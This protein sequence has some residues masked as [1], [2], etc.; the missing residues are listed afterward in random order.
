[1]NTRSF[2]TALQIVI[3]AAGAALAVMSENAAAQIFGRVDRI[4]LVDNV[5]GHILTLAPPSPLVADQVVIIPAMKSGGAFVMSNST[6]GQTIANGVTLSGS[7]LEWSNAML[8]VAPAITAA[9]GTYY[10]MISN[11]SASQQSRGVELVAIKA[12]ASGTNELAVGGSFSATGSGNNVAARFA[13]SGGASNTGIEVT[14]GG[15]KIS[16]GIDNNAGGMNEVGSM[17]GVTTLSAESATLQGK[18]SATLRLQP[19]KMASGDFTNI[20]F[21]DGKSREMEIRYTSD[22]TP[23]ISILG[24]GLEVGSGF[25]VSS[26]GDVKAKRLELSEAIPIAKGGTGI[27]ATNVER[28]KIFA[29]PSNA[30]G[31]P[32]FRELDITDLPDLSSLYIESNSSEPQAANLNIDGNA[33]LGGDLVVR[34]AAGIAIPGSSTASV[35]SFGDRQGDRSLQFKDGSGN[36]MALILDRGT[37]GAINASAGFQVAGNASSGSILRGNGSEFVASIAS[38]P[39]V[40]K[41]GELM[42]SSA[43]NKITG[44]ATIDN[45]VL[46]TST[47]G[48]PSI[49]SALPANVQKNITSLGTI[50]SGTWNATPLNDAAVDNKLTI[51]DGT[52]NATPI[53]TA[54]ASTGS[55]TALTAN[56]VVTFSSL[57]A[58]LV[59]S[60]ASGVL[61]ASPISNN[62]IASNAAISGSKI[63]ADFGSQEIRTSGGLNVT[64]GG[65]TLGNANSTVNIPGLL[66]TGTVAPTALVTPNVHG[67]LA[68]G[69]TLNLEGSNNKAPSGDRVTITTD[70]VIRATFDA[71]GAK[72]G[73]DLRFTGGRTIAPV[74]SATGYSLT[75]SGGDATDRNPGARLLLKGGSGSVI[76]TV[77]INTQGGDI[78]LGGRGSQTI[79][80]GSLSVVGGIDN[81]RGGITEAGSITG[82]TSIGASDVTISSFTRPGVVHNDSRG[83][84]ISGPVDLAEDVSGVLDVSS[85]GTGHARVE[86]NL[87]FAGPAAGVVSAAPSFRKLSAGDLPPSSGNYIQNQNTGTQAGAAFNIDGSGFVGGKMVVRGNAILGDSINDNVSLLG[88]VNTS[89][90]FAAGADRS[91]SV[92]TNAPTLAG[93]SLTINAGNAGTGNGGSISINGG[94][95]SGGIAGSVNINGGVSPASTSGSLIVLAG[96]TVTGT[97]GSAVFAGGDASGGGIGGPTIIRGGHTKSGSAGTVS[98]HGG[99]VNGN[100]P[101]AVNIN[102]TGTDGGNV[103]IGN[104]ATMLTL[105]TANLDIS[106]GG[107]ISGATGITSSG[108]ITFSSLESGVVKSKNGSLSASEL[109]I[110]EIPEEVATDLELQ[111]AIANAVNGKRGA[112]AA[113][114]SS[115]SIGEA[116]LSGDVTTKGTSQTTLSATGVTAGSYG[117]GSTVPTI[118]IDAKGRITS[119]ASTSIK[120]AAIELTGNTLAPA[121]T[122]SSLQSVGT[123]TTGAWRGSVIADAYLANDLTITG[124][125]IDATDIGLVTPRNGVFTALSSSGVITGGG[126]ITLGDDGAKAARGSVVLEDATATNGFDATIKSVDQLTDDRTYTLPDLSGT[127]ALIETI[128]KNS[129][130]TPRVSTPLIQSDDRLT[131]KSKGLIVASDIAIDGELKV[132]N[133]STPFAGRAKITAHVDGTQKFTIKNSQSHPTS[134]IIVTPV[135]SSRGLAIP[136]AVDDQSK[137]G[138]F[139]VLVN[140]LLT[141]ESLQLYY[142]IIN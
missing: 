88:L 61:S 79:V 119:A 37:T 115:N 80:N 14:S 85:G 89:I 126:L 36:V 106:P 96:T 23:A 22:Q 33:M 72:I 132:G 51:T 110:E 86:P 17:S 105:N 59:R 16:G 42:Y 8:L 56:G 35:V 7:P 84:L 1:M 103:T 4:T 113:F 130:T 12:Q 93:N 142:M 21:A 26:T 47:S 122:S 43:D 60:N 19:E 65:I 57:K 63:N 29:S 11:V 62:D 28:R 52:I 81:N 68:P 73:G 48:S 49:G 3:C 124:G 9:R 137:E 127:I 107:A 30:A 91:I 53:G 18:N 117:S 95:A 87:I 139:D 46:V 136:I 69:A 76:G 138:Q 55:F 58:G 140:D 94:D 102:T 44:L 82:I 112:L 92:A 83:E 34:G 125:K 104:G 97:G 109:D 5:T 141:G 78:S 99:L 75:V 131:M 108:A 41:Q 101:S 20:V 129:L 27:D 134:L 128:G 66:A 100:S 114:T 67:G 31:A 50:T 121:V 98:I 54:T 25:S 38:Y 39:N 40:T 123:I 74:T 90:N 32:T 77:E 120:A 64:A 70:N 15:A 24:G 133:T 135:T 13:A 10:G 2:V 45:G 6:A 116:D 111:S 71:S 118:T